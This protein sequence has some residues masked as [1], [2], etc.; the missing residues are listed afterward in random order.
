MEI[1]RFWVK[2][3]ALTTAYATRYV[4]RGVIGPDEFHSVYPAV[5]MTASDNNAY[6]NVMAVW[7]I[8]RAL[9]ALELLPLLDRIDLLERLCRGMVWSFPTGKT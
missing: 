5:L 9:E 4:I 6:T 7:V 2:W 3:P 1:A 8:T